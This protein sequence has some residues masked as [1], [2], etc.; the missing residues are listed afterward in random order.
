MNY[1]LPLRLSANRNYNH[2]CSARGHSSSASTIGGHDNI[3][4]SRVRPLQH[5][6][7]QSLVIF[8]SETNG[9]LSHRRYSAKLHHL[10]SSPMTLEVGTM[11]VPFVRY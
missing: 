5:L 8:H 9:L 3:A 2:A 11:M 6:A 1:S 10:Q 4:C 7:F